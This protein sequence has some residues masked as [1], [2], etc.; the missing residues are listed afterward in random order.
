MPNCSVQSRRRVAA[1]AYTD[2]DRVVAFWQKVALPT[3]LAQCWLWTGG[4][5]GLGYGTLW[6]GKKQVYAHRYSYELHREAIPPGLTIDHLCR[7]PACVNPWHMEVVTLTE[8]IRR[9]SGPSGQNRQKTHCPRGHA[10]TPENTYTVL[11]R[12]RWPTRICKA[13]LLR[14]AL[15]EQRKLS[16]R[17]W[18]ARQAAGVTR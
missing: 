11:R 3:D 1:G 10:Y 7:T 12:G 17:R 5:A 9:G 2:A 16:T 15:R 14:P 6:N 4:T 13:C 8:N 18:R